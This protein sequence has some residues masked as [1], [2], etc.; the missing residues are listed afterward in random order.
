MSDDLKTLSDALGNWLARQTPGAQDMTL[1]DV[2]EPAQ[3]YS[4]RTILFTARWEEAG[5][6]RTRDLVARLQRDVSCPLLDDVFHQHGV[7]AVASKASDVLVPMPVFAEHDPAPLGTPFFV[8][9]RAGGQV[10][11]DF[12]SYH[13]EG[14]VADLP[15]KERTQ[16]W[17]NGIEAMERLHRIDWSVFETLTA[18]QQ[19]PPDARFYI[20]RFIMPWF[21]WAAKGTRFPV[22]EEAIAEMSA[23]APAVTRSGLAWNDARMGNVMFGADNQVSA[24]FDFE[25]ATLGPA[26]ID[27]AWWLYAD[28][29]FSESF[30]VARLPGI[31]QGQDA[32]GGFEARYG[33]A[34]PDFS[35]YLALAALKHA[36]ISIK[37]YGNDKRAPSPEGLA[38][39][40]VERMQHYLKEYRSIAA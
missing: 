3:G 25:V 18:G 5:Q 29:I 33:Y 36:V 4:S 8:M 2:I 32:I 22:I 13:S 40:P 34:M 16:L 14:W 17:W 26:E 1:S 7:M 10:P 28:D 20:E 24:L 21:E 31:P 23:T 12:P 11:S 19:T 39:F 35:Y 15:L 6:T 9:E 37:D 38:P 27:L 30:G